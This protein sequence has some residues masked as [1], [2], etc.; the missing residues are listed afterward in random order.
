MGAFF[1]ILTQMVDIIDLIISGDIRKMVRSVCKSALESCGSGGYES[2]GGNTSPV[3]SPGN[4]SL[5]GRKIIKTP[6]KVNSHHTGSISSA[7]GDFFALCRQLRTACFDGSL[8]EY[9]GVGGHVALGALY[10]TPWSPDLL[11]PF[12]AMQAGITLFLGT[13]AYF[14]TR[15]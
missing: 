13:G 12:L 3:S 15:S 4:G 7:A 6:S 2:K 14:V 11:G 9:V 1:L 8:E 10:C 5:V